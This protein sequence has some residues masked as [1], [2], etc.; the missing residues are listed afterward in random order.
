MQHHLGH[1]RVDA[2]EHHLVRTRDMLEAEVVISVSDSRHGQIG[3]EM[4]LGEVRKRGNM[5]ERPTLGITTRIILCLGPV[6]GMGRSREE[7][8]LFVRIKRGTDGVPLCNFA[9]KTGAGTSPGGCEGKVLVVITVM[10]QDRNLVTGTP[11][12][13]LV[14]L[15]RGFGELGIHTR[16]QRENVCTRCRF[17]ILLGSHLLFGAG[18]AKKT[19]ERNKYKPLFHINPSPFK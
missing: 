13:G 16:L 11:G 12:E 17:G 19:G 15:V 2:A 10:E 14:P 18:G 9:A 7:R 4:R 6:I 8:Y 5:E 3:R 1:G